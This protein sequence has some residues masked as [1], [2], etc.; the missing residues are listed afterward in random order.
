MLNT[1]DPFRA[2]EAKVRFEMMD[3]EILT[4]GYFVL[5]AVTGARIPLDELRYWNVELQEPYASPAIALQ[6]WKQLHGQ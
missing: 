6:R 1:S 2:T 3:F 4:Q 5:C